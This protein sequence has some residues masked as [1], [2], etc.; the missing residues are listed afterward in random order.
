MTSFLSSEDQPSLSPDGSRVAFIWDGDEDGV[1]DVYI[2]A[3][4]PDSKQVRGIPRRLTSGSVAH[5]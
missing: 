2:S 1:A 5:C 3:I 4:D